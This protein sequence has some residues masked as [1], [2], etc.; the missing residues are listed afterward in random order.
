MVLF[1]IQSAAM[2]IWLV[3]LG[4]ILD[5]HGLGEIKPFSF[6]VH[7]IAAVIS[8]LFVGAKAD[9]GQPA[10]ILS[11]M[12]MLSALAMAAVSTAIQFHL[13]Q[14][15]ILGL[16][17]TYALCSAPLFSITT[18]LIFGQLENPHHEYGPIRSLGTIG[19]MFGAL[20][21]SLLRLDASIYTGYVGAV[22]WLLVS[23]F[24]CFLSRSKT[25]RAIRGE[26]K[27]LT[28]RERLGLDA[29]VLLKRRDIRVLLLTTM[30]LTIP[31][32]SFYPFAPSH[33]RDL[34]FN[35]T[36][37]WMSLAQSTEIIAMFAFAWL[38]HKLGTRRTILC[39]VAIV[40]IRFVSS[41]FNTPT[42][43]I[44]N[45]ILH[46]AGFVLIFISTQIYFKET[47]DAAWTTR[48][49]AL[50]TFLNDGIGNL[51]GYLG[52]GRWHDL[53]MHGTA[54]NWPRFW[55]GLAAFAVLVWIVF[56]TLFPTD[57]ERNRNASLSPGNQ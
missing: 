23:A 24:A 13:N 26:K 16:I 2:A 1:F 28:F 20:L 22:F 37:A 57:I 21:I 48:A 17:Q 50:M 10:V 53:C 41:A 9:K 19:W 11:F 56:W 52:S 30:L 12:A 49:L 14:W 25:W 8:P 39:G 36:S 31:L 55:G 4:T 34:G 40:V 42:M 7:A 18:A 5:A 27:P 32:G 29:M 15:L 44:V 46:G 33:L 6:A 35:R 51:I 43:H 38:Y 45:V 54:C 47:I 3:P